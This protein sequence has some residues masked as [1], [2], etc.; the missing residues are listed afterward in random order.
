MIELLESSRYTQPDTLLDMMWFHFRLKS[1]VLEPVRETLSRHTETQIIQCV[2]ES[3]VFPNWVTKFDGLHW[4]LNQIS[5]QLLP[6]INQINASTIAV[7]RMNQYPS[8][9]QEPMQTTVNPTCRP[10]RE[11]AQLV[12]RE[13]R[14]VSNG[15][16]KKTVTFD[17]GPPNPSSSGQRNITHLS[18]FIGCA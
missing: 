16:Q 9:V 12:Q 3:M 13:T 8:S 14:R 15:C 4:N 10:F 17:A 1:S 11:L 5:A 18:Y 6:R 2:K 7:K